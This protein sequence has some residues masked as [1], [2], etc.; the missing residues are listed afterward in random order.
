MCLHLEDDQLVTGRACVY[1]CVALE[2]HKRLHGQEGETLTCPICSKWFSHK[3]LMKVHVDNHNKQLPC[4]VCGQVFNGKRAFKAHQLVHR[5]MLMHVCEVCGERF[6]SSE[7]LSIHAQT[8]NLLPGQTA[9]H[10][11]AEGRKALAE[12]K[13]QKGRHAC[14][15]CGKRFALVLMQLS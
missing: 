1:V 8:H 4:E 2:K 12:K 5:N 10:V 3:S 14:D 11:M 7:V 15:K 6:R 9:Q 13:A